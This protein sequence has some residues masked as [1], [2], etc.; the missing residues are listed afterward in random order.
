MIYDF[1]SCFVRFKWQWSAQQLILPSAA[2]SPYPSSFPAF[3]EG[4]FESSRGDE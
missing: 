2:A 4:D 3:S 1:F